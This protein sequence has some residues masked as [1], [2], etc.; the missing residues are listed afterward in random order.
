M[1]VA[2]KEKKDLLRTCVNL[3]FFFFPFFLFSFACGIQKF[4]GQGLYL[5]HSSD[6]AG[7]LTCCAT[8]ELVNLVFKF[9]KVLFCIGTAKGICVVSLTEILLNWCSVFK[10]LLITI[11]KAIYIKFSSK[12]IFRF[13]NK[14]VLGIMNTKTVALAS[15][16]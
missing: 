2:K 14:Y 5:S 12:F 9:G 6:N 3:F 1:G 4:L 8:R 13:I 10:F 15:S 16:H 7:S 11:E